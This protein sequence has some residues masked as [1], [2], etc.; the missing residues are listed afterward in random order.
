MELKKDGMSDE[1]DRIDG[2][3]RIDG[4]RLAC[5]GRTQKQTEGKEEHEPTHVLFGD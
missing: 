3:G 2:E 5:E 4:A 1:G